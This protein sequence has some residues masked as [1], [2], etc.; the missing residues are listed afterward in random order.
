[1]TGI[2]QDVSLCSLFM[3]YVPVRK[4]INKNANPITSWFFDPFLT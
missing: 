2:K 1:M 3:K 4:E